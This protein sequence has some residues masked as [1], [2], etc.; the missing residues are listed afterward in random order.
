MYMPWAFFAVTD[1][2]NSLASSILL[3]DCKA[4]TLCLQKGLGAEFH[5]RAELSIDA[6]SR[7][8]SSSICLAPVVL[9][10][11]KK[12]CSDNRARDKTEKT[13]TMSSSVFRRMCLRAIR[14]CHSWLV[15]N[16]VRTHTHT[17]ASMHVHVRVYTYTCP[18]SLHNS[19]NCTHTGWHTP[20]CGNHAQTRTRLIPTCLWGCLTHTHVSACL[21]W[22]SKAVAAGIFDVQTWVVF[23]DKS[24][25]WV[26][27]LPYG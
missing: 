16:L 23:K 26:A 3:S 15:T 20:H 17:H 7:P 21:P 18:S 5:H 27:L 10:V 12:T 14:A 22:E 4:G 13:H 24:C 9:A 6:I 19:N 1:L 11:E 2:L 8:T 25:D